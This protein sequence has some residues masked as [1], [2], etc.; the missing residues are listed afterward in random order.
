MHP[1]YHS[2]RFWMVRRG[3]L[4][5]Y[6]PYVQKLVPNGR[7]ELGPSVRRNRHRNAEQGD[8][9][10][11]HGIDDGQKNGP[12]MRIFLFVGSIFRNIQARKPNLSSE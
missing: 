4:V 8:P 7:V 6:S 9:A 3:L 11:G 10:M 5:L 1:F 12:E 2:I